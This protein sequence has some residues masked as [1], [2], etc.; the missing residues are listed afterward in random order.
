[1]SEPTAQP[2]LEEQARRFSDKVGHLLRA[3][4]P[5]APGMIVTELDERVRI[6]PEGQ[7]PRAGG[8]PLRA[9]ALELAWLRVHYSCRLDHVERYLAVDA[10]SFWVVSTKDRSP[11][12]RFEYK[13][14]SRTAPHA[15]IQLHGE[16]GALT[17]L[18][19]RCG[20]NRAHEMSA[21][22]LPT[23]GPRFRPNLEDVIQFL[24]D[25]VGV[26]AVDGWLDAVHERRAEWRSIQTKAAARAMAHD[27]AEALR[28]IGYTV[29]PP[30]EGE[31]EP[32]HKARFAW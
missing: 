7:T 24:I 30:P 29:T 17:H 14:Q 22:H 16:R 13:Y 32:G 26:D 3:C 12:I 27:A 2:S 31:P 6:H 8:V 1:M 4:F 19:T 21:L 20:H 5:D 9:N 11:L 25:D 23:G 15:H 18:L 28:E 10:A